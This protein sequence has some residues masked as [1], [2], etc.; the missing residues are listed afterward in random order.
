MYPKELRTAKSTIEISLFLFF[1]GHNSWQK[2][3]KRLDRTHSHPP[4]HP[5]KKNVA[6][7]V[8][9]FEKGQLT[10]QFILKIMNRY[11]FYL[12]ASL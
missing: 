10:I 3:I 9:D 1:L 4:P 5:K 11:V 12:E 6:K 8:T 7:G 2:K